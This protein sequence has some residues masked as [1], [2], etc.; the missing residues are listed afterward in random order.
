MLDEREALSKN[1]KLHTSASPE[2]PGTM[3]TPCVTDCEGWDV[4]KKS[5]KINKTFFHQYQPE[6]FN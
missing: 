1:K 5:I 2:G 6:A 4:T 3:V